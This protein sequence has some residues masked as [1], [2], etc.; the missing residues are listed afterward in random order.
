MVFFVGEDPK[1]RGNME[2]LGLDAR[3]LKRILQK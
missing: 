3:T 1:E 2:D